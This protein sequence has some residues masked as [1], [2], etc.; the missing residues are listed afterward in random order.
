MESRR[1][2][3]LVTVRRAG[4]ANLSRNDVFPITTVMQTRLPNSSQT[5]R[6]NIF[7]HGSRACTIGAW[8]R[9]YLPRV[10]HSFTDPCALSITT[11]LFR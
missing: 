4:P 2:D 7:S 8:P 11:L 10:N 1:Y 3:R 6:R 9:R 5:R